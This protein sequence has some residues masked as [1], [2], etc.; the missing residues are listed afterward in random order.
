[1]SLKKFDFET[2]SV[3][4]TGCATA[5]EE[6]VLRYGLLWRKTYL[7]ARLHLRRKQYV[8]LDRLFPY[9]NSIRPALQAADNGDR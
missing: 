2:N 9:N 5:E 1:M 4:K 7:N 3:L 6:A 8:I